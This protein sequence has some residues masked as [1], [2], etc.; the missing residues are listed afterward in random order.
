MCDASGDVF[1][2]DGVYQDA[3]TGNPMKCRSV[4]RII[5][6]KKCTF[7]PFRVGSDGKMFRALDV[8]C[9]RERRPDAHRPLDSWRHPR[10]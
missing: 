5:N 10:R 6:G 2:L 7:E 1:T 4:T 3:A 8:I 9:A